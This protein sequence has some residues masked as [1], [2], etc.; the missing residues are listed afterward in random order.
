MALGIANAT[1]GRIYPV[2]GVVLSEAVVVTQSGV[3]IIGIRDGKNVVETAIPGISIDG[4]VVAQTAKIEIFIAALARA[5]MGAAAVSGAGVF[6]LTI[7]I[8][9]IAATIAI[10]SNETMRDV[11]TDPEFWDAVGDGRVN[12]YLTQKTGKDLSEF[13]KAMW[14]AFLNGDISSIKKGVNDT[15]SDTFRTATTPRAIA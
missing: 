10:A 15:V 2:V 9:A 6:G 5:A 1:I 11:I 4:N 12:D 3:S 7:G 13:A 8:T 14:E